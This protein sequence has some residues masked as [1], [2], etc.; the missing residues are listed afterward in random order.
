MLFS[1]S[2][3]AISNTVYFAGLASGSAGV[4]TGTINFWS[5]TYGGAGTSTET[6]LQ[7]TTGGWSVSISDEPSKTLIVYYGSGSNL[8]MLSSVNYGTTWS[9]ALTISSSETSVTGVSAADNGIGAI[10]TSGSSS[11]FNVRFAANPMLSTVN[12]SP[13]AVHMI[14]LYVLNTVSST[15]VHFD[16]NSSATGVTAAFDNQIGAGETMSIPLS[17][18][19]WSTS[20]SYVITLTTD[21]GVVF[22]STETSPA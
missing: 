1:S 21:Q 13:F 2:A 17:Y 8:Y 20:Q 12:N 10:W 18:F 15:L 5:F 14:S 16:T 11:P 22:T 7:G 4:T 3:S 9:S 6:Q 19:A